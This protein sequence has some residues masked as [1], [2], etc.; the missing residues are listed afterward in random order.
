MTDSSNSQHHHHVHNHNHDMTSFDATLSASSQSTNVYTSSMSMTFGSFGDY[1][2]SI[3]F[4]AWTTSTPAEF[5][6]AWFM[7]VLLVIGYHFL[8]YYTTVVEDKIVEMNGMLAFADDIEEA[9][10]LTEG[11]PAVRRRGRSTDGSSGKHGVVLALREK[12]KWRVIHA[13]ISATT[14]GV[15]CPSNAIFVLEVLTMMFS[16]LGLLLMLVAMTYNVLLFVALVVGY[17]IGDAI[18]FPADKLAPLDRFS[19]TRDSCH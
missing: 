17:G 14:Y 16:Q 19:N 12:M 7:V 9:A 5:A 1:R 13:L 6:F 3:W 8:R 2:T 18:F 15:S 4:S 10:P 11:V